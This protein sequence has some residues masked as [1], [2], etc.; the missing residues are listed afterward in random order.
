[1][2]RTLAITHARGFLGKMLCQQALEQ[3]FTVIGLVFGEEDNAYNIPGVRYVSLGSPPD[4]VAGGMGDDKTQKYGGA[5]L[6]D[7]APDDTLA[8][9]TTLIDAGGPYSL[10][11]ELLGHDI[12]LQ[13]SRSPEPLEKAILSDDF[14]Q[15][16]EAFYSSTTTQILNL[17]LTLPRLE[18][19]IGLSSLSL[20]HKF[21]P[22]DQTGPKGSSEETVAL[23]EKP[24]LHE[25]A[26]LIRNPAARLRLKKTPMSHP[27]G[28][29]ALQFERL[30]EGSF[31]WK[32][33]DVLRTV[34]RLGT[35]IGH[36][37]TGEYPNLHG[38]YSLI[39]F[40]HQLARGSLVL[41]RLP[42]LPLPFSERWRLSLI[43][44]DIASKALLGF[45]STDYERKQRQKRPLKSVAYR[46]LA[47]PERDVSVRRVFSA[48]FRYLGL[49]LPPFAIGSH[50]FVDHLYRSLGLETKMLELLAL[51]IPAH[52]DQFHR[53]FPGFTMKPMIEYFPIMIDYAQKHLLHKR[54]LR[55]NSP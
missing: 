23:V 50:F 52:A 21:D 36:S 8:D 49:E 53:E 11:T 54:P 29:S 47:E 43:P 32:R 20:G 39:P 2:K 25:T 7:R 41:N 18:H 35:L 45:C 19:Y 26:A 48:T 44:V 10:D 13:G 28:L 1:M 34:V 3:G 4:P 12:P 14:T 27:L 37:E 55:G 38:L 17:A 22:L 51:Q 31:G 24:I 40:C 6:H 30:V 33:P 5:N 46:H 42:L 9:I 16:L 15:A